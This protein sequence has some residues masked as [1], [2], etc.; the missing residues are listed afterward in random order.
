MGMENQIVRAGGGQ[1]EAGAPQRMERRGKPRMIEQP[2]EADV[3]FAEMWRVMRKRRAVIAVSTVLLFGAAVVYT[4]FL[5]PRY[6]TTSV[7]EFN[8]ANADSLA[9]DDEQET[10]RGAN[11]VEYNVTQQT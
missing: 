6:R 3:S 5:T 9:L 10:L 11:A 8:K 2:V 4:L 7:I 1:P